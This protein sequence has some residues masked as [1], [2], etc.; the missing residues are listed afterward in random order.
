MG[1]KVITEET[2]NNHSGT[3]LTTFETS[4]DVDPAAPR[5]YKERR[6]TPTGELVTKISDDLNVD[7]RKVR[8][9]VMVNRQNKTIRPDQPIMDL[10]PTVEDTFQRAAA[11]RDPCLRVW[12]EVAEEVDAE[13]NA[14]WPTY[15]GQLNGIVVK[16]DLILLFLK[17]FD[18]EK[19]T[20]R[21][22]GHVYISKEK[23]VEELLPP[24]MKK[25]GWGE[26]L[27]SDEKIVLWEVG[28]NLDRLPGALL[29]S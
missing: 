19:Q 17:C 29:T 15:Q 27:A 14:V 11:H 5:F 24:I 3:D 12:A 2:F 18:A 16:N 20:L 4:P 1:V 23:K 21:G 10:R 28:C 7:P 25:M 8:L 9:W 6:I 26:K 13:G 22:V